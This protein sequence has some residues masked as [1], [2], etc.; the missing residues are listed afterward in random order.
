MLDFIKICKEGYVTLELAHNDT[1]EDSGLDSDDD[2]V[3]PSS[4]VLT[5]DEMSFKVRM[6]KLELVTNG[7]ARPCEKYSLT[8]EKKLFSRLFNFARYK[9]MAEISFDSRSICCKFDPDENNVFC[10]IVSVPVSDVSFT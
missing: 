3:Q 1:D 6:S 4:L 7:D 8:M 5:S 9:A 2:E 10:L